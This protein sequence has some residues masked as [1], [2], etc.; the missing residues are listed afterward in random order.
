MS[1]LSLVNAACTRLIESGIRPE[2]AG[3][4]AEV[5]ARH[6]LGWDRATYFTERHQKMTRAFDK[7]YISLIARRAR[8]EP[9][10]YLTGMREFW[11]LEFTVT[12]DTLIPRPETE[13]LIETVLQLRPDRSINGVL[14]DVGTGSGCIAVVLAVEF[15]NMTIVAT[16]IS[17][18]A[19]AVAQANAKRHGVSDRIELRHGPQLAGLSGS[20]D[21]IVSNPPYITA[22]AMQ[23]LAPEVRDH[24]PH[25]ALNGGAGGTETLRALIEKTSLKL[26]NNGSLIVEFGCDQEAVFRQIANATHLTDIQVVHDIQGLPRVGVA[27]CRNNR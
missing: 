1:I 3:L 11:G 17:K 12:P 26:A 21:L 15:P 4:D 10:A 7:E 22:Q 18:P 16:D 14:V 5:L 8:R 19:L 24:E 6:L 13:L 20:L 23:H 27:T 2:E 25:L 9:V